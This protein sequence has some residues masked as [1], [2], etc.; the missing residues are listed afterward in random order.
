MND[1]SSRAMTTGDRAPQ[2][3]PGYPAD[4]YAPQECECEFCS[5]EPEPIPA[6]WERTGDEERD[7]RPLPMSAEERALALTP[8]AD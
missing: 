7:L 3:E 5:P 1:D 2:A 6:P 8:Q 4:G